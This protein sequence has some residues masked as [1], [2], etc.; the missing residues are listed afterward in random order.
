MRKILPLNEGDTIQ[1]RE[2]FVKDKIGTVGDPSC[3]E[4][5]KIFINFP[6]GWCGWHERKNLRI[7]KRIKR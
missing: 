5:D 1:I 2:G 4:G 6:D 3:N 7:L